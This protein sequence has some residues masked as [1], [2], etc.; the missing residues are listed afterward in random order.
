MSTTSQMDPQKE[1]ELLEGFAKSLEAL[2][3]EGKI[4]GILH[5]RNDSVADVVK[6][7]ETRIL[8]GQDFFYEELLGLRFR[9]SVFSFFQTNS[10]GAQILYQTAREYIGDLGK[11]D[12]VV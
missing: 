6:S 12:C 7:D 1:G 8:R 4:A 3:L 5:I 9:I 2:E 11:K 10:Y